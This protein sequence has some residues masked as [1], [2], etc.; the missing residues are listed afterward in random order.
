[1]S[2]FTAVN[3]P[4]LLDFSS[5]AAAGNGGNPPPPGKP[6][7]LWAQCDKEG[8]GLELTGEFV[9]VATTTRKKKGNGAGKEPVRRSK[10]ARRL[11][12][13]NASDGGD[14]CPE[15]CHASGYLWWLGGPEELI[16]AMAVLPESTAHALRVFNAHQS[17]RR[18][19][20]IKFS[21]RRRVE[22]M[23]SEASLEG[24]DGLGT[25]DEE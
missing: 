17:C 11:P 6:V 19:K 14:S 5:A 10:R 4:R 7:N 2:V 18:H 23:G 12:L 9:V 20:Y 25:A 1:M 8:A 3:I 16:V 24:K 15:W 13:D 21:E 22:E